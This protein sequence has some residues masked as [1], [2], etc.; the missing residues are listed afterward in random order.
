MHL[1]EILK[2]HIRWIAN[3]GIKTAPLENLR[4]SLLPV[5]GVYPLFF[6]VAVKTNSDLPLKKSGLIRLLP[7]RM[8]WSREDSGLSPRAV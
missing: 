7:S 5:E 8:F 1:S 6:D 4:K 2:F 3:D